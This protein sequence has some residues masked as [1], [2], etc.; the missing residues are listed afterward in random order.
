MIVV[1]AGEDPEGG[2]CPLKTFESNFIHHDFVH[3]GKQKSRYKA[4]LSSVVWSQRCCEVCFISLTVG[5]SL[6][7]L[8]TKYFWNRPPPNLA[9]WI[10]P[11]RGISDTIVLNQYAYQY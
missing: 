6:W 5:K 4:I 2:N 11:G 1:E 8:T 10:R 3:F 9:G 7:D